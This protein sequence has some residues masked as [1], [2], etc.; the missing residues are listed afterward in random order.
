MI[1]GFAGIAI[2]DDGTPWESEVDMQTRVSHYLRDIER[3]GLIGAGTTL[4]GLRVTYAAWLKRHGANDSEVAAGLGDKSARMGAHHTRHVETEA[5]VV[6]A[7]K[8]VKD[9]S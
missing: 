8:R 1:D 6:R 4:H 5:N 7:F 3:D 9:A 2:R